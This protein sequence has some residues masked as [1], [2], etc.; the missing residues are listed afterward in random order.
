LLRLFREHGWLVGVSLDGPEGMHDRYRTDR[1]GKGAWKD[2]MRGVEALRRN[3]VELN[4]LCV[5]SQANVEE[6]DKVY[7]F[8]RAAGVEHIQYIP[9]SEH[10]GGG[11]PLP[12]AMHETCDNYVVVEYNGDVYPCDFFVER[13]WLLGN[14]AVNS[15]AEI[16]RSQ[17]RYAFAARKAATHPACRVCAYEPLC[18]GG[19]PKHRYD[20]HRQFD[21][22]DYFCAAN[23]M[24][25]SNAARPLAREL[26]GLLGREIPAV[27]GSAISAAPTPAL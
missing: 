2:V 8:F 4:V 24:I 18:H 12:C 5:L 9:L 21:G 13:G 10:D 1:Q 22:L 15:W 6:P 20:A 19:C 26:E 25:F 7:R 27:P 14:V 23:Q 17:A 16:E 11:R 3:G